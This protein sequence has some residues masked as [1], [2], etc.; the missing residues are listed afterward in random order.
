MSLAGMSMIVGYKMVLVAVSA[1]LSAISLPAMPMC[2]GGHKY[3][4]YI[5]IKCLIIYCTVILT[6]ISFWILYK[7][8]RIKYLYMAILYLLFILFIY[9]VTGINLINFM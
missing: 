4:S 9:A 2:E 1:D 7:V 3:I 8:I 5:W 6:V